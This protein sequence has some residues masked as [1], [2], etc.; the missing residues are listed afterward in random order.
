[1]SEAQTIVENLL[2]AVPD[3]YTAETKQ[4]FRESVN[5]LKNYLLER[6]VGWTDRDFNGIFM[7]AVFFRSLYDFCL[8]QEIISEPNW[9]RNFKKIES[10]W[11]HYCNCRERVDF[12]TGHFG[13]GRLGDFLK[14]LSTVDDFFLNTFGSGAYMSPTFVS[15]KLLCSICENDLRGCEHIAGRVY[16]GRLCFG[17]PQGIRMESVSLVT[18][19]HDPR[20]RIWPW[21]IKDG[22]SES[23]I[24]ASVFQ[25]DDFMEKDDWR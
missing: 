4:T 21:S 2:H 18:S 13:G 16:S 10:L 3:K 8:I 25:I 22:K 17:R 9:E 24:I 6:P 7:A 23:Q 1:M 20:C 5:T 14:S 12:W 15:E 19:P 11:W